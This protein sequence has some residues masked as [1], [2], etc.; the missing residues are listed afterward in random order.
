[1]SNT[2]AG[3]NFGGKAAERVQRQLEEVRRENARRVR[4]ARCD[5]TILPENMDRHV[6]LVHDEVLA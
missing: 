4:C 1:M 2:H 6:A 3:L 5:L